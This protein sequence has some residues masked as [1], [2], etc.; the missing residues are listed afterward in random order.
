M[1]CVSRVNLLWPRRYYVY[2]SER[3][4]F[5]NYL[6]E[7]YYVY[8]NL[9]LLTGMVGS[10]TSCVLMVFHYIVK[11]QQHTKIWNG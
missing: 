2:E 1:C 11:Q 10:T 5:I 3:K 6:S 4:L 8:E 7:R 9:F